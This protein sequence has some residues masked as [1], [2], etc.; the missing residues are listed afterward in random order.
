MCKP[1]ERTDLSVRSSSQGLMRQQLVLMAASWWHL[2]AAH[3]DRWLRSSLGGV[4]LFLVDAQRP[5]DRSQ[6]RPFTNRP[7]LLRFG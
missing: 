2:L 6:I 7:P 4:A 1:T 5:A 3:R